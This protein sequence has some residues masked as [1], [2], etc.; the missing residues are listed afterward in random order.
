MDTLL[1]TLIRLCPLNTPSQQPIYTHIQHPTIYTPSQH[2][3][4]HTQATKEAEHR[5]RLQ[6]LLSRIQSLND[7]ISAE[8]AGRFKWADRCVPRRRRR[9]WMDSYT[10]CWGRCMYGDT[11]YFFPRSCVSY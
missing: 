4:T 8:E 10:V 1:Y 2:P 3:F 5:E 11:L 6:D 7:R 9:G